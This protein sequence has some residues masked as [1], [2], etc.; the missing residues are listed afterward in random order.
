MKE[1]QE[2]RLCLFSHSSALNGAERCLFDL[3]KILISKG[4]SCAVIMPG[5]GSLKSECE[6]LGVVVK[7]FSAL[8]MWCDLSD[9]QEEVCLVDLLNILDNEL[10][11]ILRF[12][13]YYSAT[14]IYSQTIVS[15][16]GAIVAESLELPHLLGIREYGKFNFYFGFKESIQ[17]LYHTS[18]YIFSVSESVAEAVLGENFQNEN[19]KVNYAKVN[20]PPKHSKALYKQIDQKIRIGIFGS[21]NENKN[22]LDI[23]K[24]VCILIEQGFKIELFI[25]GVLEQSYYQHLLEFIVCTTYKK[26]IVFTG[27]TETP[28]DIMNTMDIVVS[29]TKVEGFGRTLI[30]AILLKIPIIYANTSGPKEIYINKKHGLAYKLGNEDNLAIQIVET[31]NFPH[32]TKQRVQKAYK[33]VINK[34]TN[35]SYAYP[36]I[37]ALHNVSDKTLQRKKKYVTDLIKLKTPI[38]DIILR[39]N[40]YSKLLYSETT[41]IVFVGASSLLE[42]NWDVL[43]KN[44][45]L[46]D[47]ICDNN[48][49][50]QEQYFMNYKIYSTED[51]FNKQNNYLVIITSSYVTE[52]KI[53]L[54]GYKNIIAI[55]SYS[56]MIIYMKNKNFLFFQEIL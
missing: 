22:Q 40:F 30:E 23:I 54:S 44:N 45:I 3:I 48:P 12:V 13:K 10:V 25:V 16:I 34:F 38:K 37:E 27:H 17:A 46:P 35:E 4:I 8:G 28:I 18:N 19:V 33:Y 14:A 50:K 21:I 6:N 52:I 15:P 20:I 7:T 24:A 29:C 32:I 26:Q 39:K 5:A 42:K 49:E 1:N 55:E 43:I 47:Y 11:D 56:N 9:E 31:I 36:I 2:I 41:K 51:V 53:Q